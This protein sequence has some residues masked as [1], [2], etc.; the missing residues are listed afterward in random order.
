MN[1]PQPENR[2]TVNCPSGHRLRGGPEMLGKNVQCPRC[3]TSFV[4]AATKSNGS[5]HRVITDTGVMRILGDMPQL[6]APPPPSQTDNHAVTDTG[7]MRILGDVSD[8][9]TPSKQSTEAALRP[10]SRCGVAI[11]EALAVCPHCNCYIGIMP[12]F[13]QKMTGNPKTSRN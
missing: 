1:K 13:L 12:S 10:C 3:H 9:P 2:I 11:Q 7:V 6:P 5:D 4:F 8:L